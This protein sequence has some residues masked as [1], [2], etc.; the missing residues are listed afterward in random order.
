[1]TQ[2]SIA[3]MTGGGDA[4]GLNAVIRAVVKRGVSV[5]GWRIVG[6]ADSFDG[7]FTDPPGITELGRDHVRG[8]L[9]FGGTILGTTNAGN[10]FDYGSTGQ[11]SDRSAEVVQRLRMIGCEGLIAIGGDGTQS[12]C[13]RLARERGVKVVGVPKTIDNDIHAT[14]Q[15]FGFDT[16]MAYATDAV[17]R[18]HTTAESHD[19]VMV[20]EVMGR[21]AGWIALGAGI[22][23]G[24]DAILI[25]EIPFQFEPLVAKIARRKTVNRGFSVVV[26]A[27]GAIPAG[28]QPF[29]EKTFN[30]GSLKLG[31]I[32][33]HVAEEI[34]R[35]TKIETRYTVLGHLLRGGSPTAHDRL[36]SSRFG[37]HAVELVHQNRWGRMVAIVDGKMT[38]V[39][40]EDAAKGFRAVNPAGDMVATARG[41]GIVF[42][43]ETPEQDLRE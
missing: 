21:H 5:L 37:N 10:P 31:G 30:T 43:D 36:L 41:M 11:R 23:G 13:A 35:R 19:R 27:E 38:D 1:M 24:A 39:P 42:G 15:C 26:V 2:R 3:I 18:L 17:D 40:I 20:V 14:E 8:I 22:A 29:M 28:G 7:L 12:I 4:P 6:I 33:R 34:A 9:R 16:A 32:G 25:P